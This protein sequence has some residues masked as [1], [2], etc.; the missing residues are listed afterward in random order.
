MIHICTVAIQPGNWSINKNKPGNK[1]R[2]YKLLSKWKQLR[3]LELEELKQTVIWNWIDVEDC[4]IKAFIFWILSLRKMWQPEKKYKGNK[5][6]EVT[7]SFSM[8]GLFSLPI[9]KCENISSI[10]INSFAKEG[11]NK[12][13]IKA[14]I[15]CINLKIINISSWKDHMTLSTRPVMNSILKCFCGRRWSI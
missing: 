8:W 7:F 2:A 10:I 14:H 15:H 6:K 12:S 5:S 3:G 13:L 11:T 9:W 1:I 4:L